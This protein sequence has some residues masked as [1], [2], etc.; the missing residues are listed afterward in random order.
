VRAAS[1]T[2]NARD[3]DVLLARAGAKI[4]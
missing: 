3:R 4:S 2:R 1:M